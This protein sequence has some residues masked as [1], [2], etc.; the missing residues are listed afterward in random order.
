[1]AS[2]FELLTI[3][4]SPGLIRL[5]L[6][7]VYLLGTGCQFLLLSICYEMEGKER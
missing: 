3:F 1:M 4:I 6:L 7:S 2:D 5:C